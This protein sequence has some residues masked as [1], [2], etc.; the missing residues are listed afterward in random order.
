MSRFRI[1]S[2]LPALVLFAASA[3]AGEAT[4]KGSALLEAPYS[5]A[6]AWY[7]THRPNLFKAANAEIIES[8]EDGRCVLL[9]KT[10]LG[11]CKYLVQETA[12][13]GDAK[14]V[15][16]VKFLQSV[17]GDVADQTM[18]VTL[19]DQNGSIHVAL[20]LYVKVDNRLAPSFVVKQVTERS[21][22]QSLKY[23]KENAR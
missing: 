6:A 17:E 1:L 19:S 21:I 9:T 4:S 15:Y 20:S 3:A 8:K 2:A 22:R 10:P 12:E 13:I 18:T 7:Q 23:L 11:P 14:T 5:G 16:R